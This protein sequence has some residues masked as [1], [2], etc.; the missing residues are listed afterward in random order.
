MIADVLR[1]A[2]IDVTVVG[3]DVVSEAV[4]C[5]RGIKIVPDVKFQDKAF[6]AVMYK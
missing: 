6:S 1:R 2:K 4:V 3:V 5:S